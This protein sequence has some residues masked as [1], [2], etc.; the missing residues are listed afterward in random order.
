MTRKTPST[1]FFHIL[2]ADL[3]VFKKIYFLAKTQTQLETEL[4]MSTGI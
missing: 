1:L 2:D 3:K 4:L